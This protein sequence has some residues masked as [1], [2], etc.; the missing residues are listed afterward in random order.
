I[1]GVA[2]IE[3]QGGRVREFEVHLDPQALEGRRLAVGDVIGAIKA[4][5]DVLSA[6]LTEQNHELYLALVDGRVEDIEGLTRLSLPVPGGP[7]AALGH[8]GRITVGDEFS[9]IRTPADGPPAVL[10]NIIRQPSA[11]TVAI[12]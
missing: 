8:L 9:Y 11:N 1:P 4:N 3:V 2:Q 12:A 10:L 7:P 5:H 6:G